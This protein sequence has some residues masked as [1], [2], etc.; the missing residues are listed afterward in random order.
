MKKKSYWTYLVDSFERDL[1]AISW[2]VNSSGFH[3]DDK[4]CLLPLKE[5][6]LK[7]IFEERPDFIVWNYAR[8]NNIKFI[9]LAKYLNIYNIV[10]DTEGI[11]YETNTY[12]NIQNRYLKYI[13]EIWCWGGEQAK[14]LKTKFKNNKIKPLIK[15]TGSIRYEYIKTLHKVNLQENI[16]KLLWNTNY[17]TLDPRFQTVFREYRERFQLH[18]Y[19]T[20]EEAFE[21]F[22]KL[23]AKRQSSYECVKALID[24]INDIELNI[25]P[26]PFESNNFYLNSQIIKSNKVKISKGKDINY[27]LENT[28]LVIQ[29]GCQTVVESF[30]RG[31]PSI[32]TDLDEINI[33]SKVTPL[34]VGDNLSTKI[35][36]IQFLELTLNKQEKL[37]KKYK[38]DKFL[39]NLFETIKINEKPIAAKN[40]TYLN[41]NI[42]RIIF[43]LKFKCKSILKDLLKKNINLSEFKKEKLSTIDIK[44][45]L[46]KK[47]RLKKTNELNCII[48]P[49][50]KKSQK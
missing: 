6:S 35:K 43:L 1:S 37:F 4:V 22:L 12:F 34:N 5:L 27:D 14:Y 33:W 8:N 26:H 17:A 18:K 25:R 36:D 42:F 41:F 47:Y 28:S 19:Q 13:D 11:H 16:G 20:E 21:F 50:I 45:F 7:F 49:N 38:I 32:R 23:S 48:Y 31:I 24:N 39:D 15:V 30:L 40:N 9:K 29:N 46:E 3:Q 2:W 10:H 44:N